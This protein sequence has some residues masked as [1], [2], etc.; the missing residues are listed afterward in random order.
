MRASGFIPTHDGMMRPCPGTRGPS[1][2][3]RDEEE[4]DDAE[5]DREDVSE[6]EDDGFLSTKL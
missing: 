3:D 1:T 6:P 2:A 5:E 4:D